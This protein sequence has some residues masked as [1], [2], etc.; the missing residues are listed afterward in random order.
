MEREGPVLETLMHR[1]AETPEEFLAEPRIGGTG[2]IHTA[3][4]VDDVLRM[5][6]HSVKSRELETF[7]GTNPR[8]DR[9]R[10]AVT[11]VLSWLLADEW[12]V[13]AQLRIADL[14]NLLGRAAMEIA[15]QVPAAKLVTDPDRRE[16]L[17]RFALARLGLRPAGETIAQA[18][19]RLMTLSSAERQRVLRASRAAEERAR[20]IR[21]AL[22]KQA[23]QESADK[24]TRE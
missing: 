4:V 19:D 5:L 2:Q 23:A 3:A 6:G 24:F 20:K 22:V 1:L 16:E 14:T 17:A 11:L 9:N 13:R 8:V 15:E 12:F 21:E 10:L 7:I 18:Q